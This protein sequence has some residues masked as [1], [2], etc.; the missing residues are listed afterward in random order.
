MDPL[1]IDTTKIK[2]A[3]KQPV[4]ALDKLND[5]GLISTVLAARERGRIDIIF[6][7]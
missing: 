1:T 2:T 5:T 3:R 4:T 7:N 6:D